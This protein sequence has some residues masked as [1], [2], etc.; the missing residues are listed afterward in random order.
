MA[1]RFLAQR[2]DPVMEGG[3]MYD[4]RQLWLL[5]RGVCADEATFTKLIEIERPWI[6]WLIQRSANSPNEVDSQGKFQARFEQLLE[7]ERTAPNKSAHWVAQKANL[8]G[9]RVLVQE[10]A[11]DGLT[12]A[13]SFFPV[14]PRL[15]LEAQLPLMR[16]M[17][18][19]FGCGNLQRA[20]TSLYR[21]LLQ[22]LDMSINPMAYLGHIGPE[23]FAFLNIFYWMSTRAP[24]PGYFLGALTYLEA[25]IPSF[26]RCYADCCRRLNIQNHHYYTEHMHIDHFHARDGQRAILESIRHGAGDYRSVWAGVQLMSMVTGEAF[27]ASVAKARRGAPIVWNSGGVESW[28]S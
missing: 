12:E 19:E 23:S 9:L 25:S 28:A 13:Q 14:L 11:V 22:E 15:P 20:H 2:S 17:L 18:D 4:L 26:F 16:I 3:F 7:S 8:D 27:E 1:H 5:N 6:S 10:F 24:G 21:A